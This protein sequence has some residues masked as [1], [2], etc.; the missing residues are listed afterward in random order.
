MRQPA[1]IATAGAA[2][3][4]KIPL[5]PRRG[6]AGG[7][8]VACYDYADE[9][10]RLLF[11]VVRY[12]PKAFRARRP[13]GQ[14]GWIR[15]LAGVRRVLYR[16]PR[17]AG[18]ARVL[19][20]EGE[21]DVES[22]EAL[23]LPPD[24]AVTC[25]PFGACQ[26]RSDYSRMLAG[27]DVYLCGDNDQA[28][29]E[30]LRQVGLALVDQ[31]ASVRLVRLPPP[32]KDLTDW[33]RDGGDTAAL[34]GLLGRAEPF[35]LTPEAAALV[36]TLRPLADAAGSAAVI[37][38]Y[39]DAAGAVRFQVLRGQPKTFR[40]RRPDGHGGFVD[41]VEGIQPLLYRLPQVLAAETVLVLEGEK[42]VE[43]AWQLG[44]PAGWAA[45][46]NPFGACQWRPE[47][48][49]AMAG[50]S[51]ILCPD[52]DPPGQAHL[53]QVGLSLL[54]QVRSIRVMSVP[55]PVKDLSEWVLA[56]GTA[57]EFRA[58]LESAGPFPYPRDPQGTMTGVADLAD[59]LGTIVRLRGVLLPSAGGGPAQPGFAPE[60]L[61]AVLPSWVTRGP[62]GAPAVCV[63][64][65]EALACGAITELAAMT[66]GLAASAAELAV[67][68]GALDGGTAE[69]GAEAD[70]ADAGPGSAAGEVAN[71]RDA[72]R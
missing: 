36:R 34:L 58:R 29:Q 67:R 69:K 12:Q 20:L 50:K 17:L 68:L 33:V 71:G 13:D 43:T 28:G 3:P 59:A 22:A 19:I 1:G 56:G 31:A 38:H 15:N 30:H 45:T 7:D 62:D 4:V 27:K 40:T 53:L 21:K 72:G 35:S 26:W 10:G 32:A 54:G 37:Y 6:P 66:R 23:G 65:F 48:S 8:I 11:Q 51:V 49:L 39:T 2:P 57:S 60:D 55:E 52:N 18:A 61:A 9:Q 16:L 41:G 46:C 5:E 44:L 70:Q 64:G 47:Y 42:D 25:S 14:G 63:R 24:L